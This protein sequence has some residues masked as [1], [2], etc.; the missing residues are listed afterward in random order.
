[1][2]NESESRRSGSETGAKAPTVGV[3]LSNYDARAYTPGAGLLRRVIWY[4]VNALVFDSWLLPWS[5]AK[6]L[7]LRLLGARIGSGVVFKPRVNIKYPWHLAVGDNSWIGEGV[8]IDNLVAVKIGAN[9]C[10]SQG[11]YLL[12]GNHDYRD[13]RFGLITGEIVIEDGAW[14]GAR[15][16]VCPGV[17]VGAEAV[18]VA[19]SVLNSDAQPGGVYRGNPAAWVRSRIAS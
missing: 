17:R 1:M 8:W 14:V 18:L 16:I 2:D 13:P 9:A 10:V 12:T 3:S 15:V 6:C 7:L 5:R 11:A 4:I 19:G